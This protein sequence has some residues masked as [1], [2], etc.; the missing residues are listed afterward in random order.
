MSESH[1]RTSLTYPPAPNAPSDP[2]PKSDRGHNQSLLVSA[3]MS[4]PAPPRDAASL[5]IHR[6]QGEALEVLMGRRPPRDRFMPDVFVFP[7]G[8]VEREDRDCPVEGSLDPSIAARFPGP[9]SD[10]QARAL[11]AAAIRETWEE[12]GLTIGRTQGTQIRPDLSALAYLGRAITPTASKIRYHARFFTASADRAHG[13]L[14]GNGELIDLS[15]I[16]IQE[17]LTLPIIDVTEALLKHMQAIHRG[18]PRGALFIHYRRGIQIIREETDRS[19]VL[20]S[21][22]RPKAGNKPPTIGRER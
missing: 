2:V 16:R 12:T 13:R 6:G 10:R 18:G 1:P 15:W 22:T 5:I 14:K 8:R 19:R 21:G 4:R 7:G 20:P 9:H 17:A 3:S 11:G